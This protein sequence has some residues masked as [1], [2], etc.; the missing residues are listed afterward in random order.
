M[1]SLANLEKLLRRFVKDLLKENF[2]N[3][4]LLNS[5]MEYTIRDEW[6]LVPLLL[7]ISGYHAMRGPGKY[8][9]PTSL[10]EWFVELMMEPIEVMVTRKNLVVT[11]LYDNKKDPFEGFVDEE[12]E[13]VKLTNEGNVFRIEEEHPLTLRMINNPRKILKYI[14]ENYPKFYRALEYYLGRRLEELKLMFRPGLL[15][16]IIKLAI[17][18][19]KEE[20]VGEI[21]NIK[22]KFLERVAKGVCTSQAAG[23]YKVLTRFFTEWELINAI[24]EGIKGAIK[25]I[26]N[27]NLD[28]YL[29]QLRE[30][31]LHLKWNNELRMELMNDISL[32]DLL[33]GLRKGIYEYCLRRYIQGLSS[34]KDIE[35]ALIDILEKILEY[36]KFKEDLG[37]PIDEE[38]IEKFGRAVLEEKKKRGISTP[39]PFEKP[40][41]GY[42]RSRRDIV[43]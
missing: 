25:N 32:E 40:I 20:I 38:L 14:R 41:L 35:E 17:L 34:D 42:L 43:K 19:D 5:N 36:L 28:P 3:T 26:K 13:G 23:W 6:M 4:S 31:L 21:K 12:M 16:H 11:P 1:I 37:I 39:L 8:F 7:G 10:I 9:L 27:G 33:R 2:I 18:M 22:N 24:K 15:E 30:T 29:Y